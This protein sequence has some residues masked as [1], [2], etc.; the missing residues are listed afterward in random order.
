VLPEWQFART[1]DPLTGYAELSPRR[2]P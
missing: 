1:H 2:K